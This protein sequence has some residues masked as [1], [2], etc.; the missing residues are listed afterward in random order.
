M[1]SSADGRR[2]LMP[3]PEV[4][5]A[6]QRSA[7][8]RAALPPEPDAGT[9][10]EAAARP[11]AWPRPRSPAAAPAAPREPECPAPAAPAPHLRDRSCALIQPARLVEAGDRIRRAPRLRQLLRHLLGPRC[12]AICGSGERGRLRGASLL[13]R[14]DHAQPCVRYATACRAAGPLLHDLPGVCI[15]RRQR[16][17]VS[18]G[19]RRGFKIPRGQGAACLAHAGIDRGAGRPCLIE[20]PLCTG[21][22]G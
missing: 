7:A 17:D 1:P 14:T 10:A 21:L 6:A 12:R 22:A 16:E 20:D 13:P 11:H 9:A 3:Q 5:V 2:A 18:G 19:S 15:L 4:S 8:E